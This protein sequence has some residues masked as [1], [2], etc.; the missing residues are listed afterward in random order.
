MD[1]PTLG[2][3]RSHW[4]LLAHEIPPEAVSMPL[5][6]L[7]V[8]SAAPERL[9]VPPMQLAR[10]SRRPL[11][12]KALQL[13]AAQQPAW[14][15]SEG[16]PPGHSDPSRSPLQGAYPRLSFWQW[17]VEGHRSVLQRSSS[18]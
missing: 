4:A 14:R 18:W 11:L 5:S 1:S 17:D 7:L 13:Q 9:A 8:R 6:A 3:G 16:T 15:G 10:V 12:E 2:S